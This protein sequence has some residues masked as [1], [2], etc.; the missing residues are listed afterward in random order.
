MNKGISTK[1]KI[2]G[3]KDEFVAMAHAMYLYKYFG[4]DANG[5]KDAMIKML[6]EIVFLDWQ[7]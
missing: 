3:I 5:L 2:C 4:I 7:V 6:K 1:L